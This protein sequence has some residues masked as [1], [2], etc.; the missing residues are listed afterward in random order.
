MTETA[1]RL[2]PQAWMK[3]A[4]CRAVM[5]ALTAKGGEARFVGGVVRDALLKRPVKDIDIA[6]PLLPAEVMKRL[7]SA[8]LRAIPT[9]LD[10]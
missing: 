9:G 4:S 1:A 8:K 7:K 2:K 6:T 10:H 5:K 3:E